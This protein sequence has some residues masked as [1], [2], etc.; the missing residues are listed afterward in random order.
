MPFKKKSKRG[1]F[2]IS[3]NKSRAAESYVE[4][5]NDHNYV[6]NDI[7]INHNETDLGQSVEV[8]PC[9]ID[10]SWKNGRRV[11]QLDILAKG[12]YCCRCNVPLHLSNIVKERLF[13]LGSVLYIRCDNSM[14][15]TVTDVHTGSRSSTGAYDINAK[16]TIG[17]YK[18]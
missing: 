6:Q 14:C 13:G 16:A 12:M 11:V 9:E 5:V 7:I 17:N 10:L 18:F 8:G 1:D 3:L 4:T 2:F 15:N